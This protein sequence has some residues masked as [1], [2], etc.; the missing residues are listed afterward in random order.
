M[1]RRGAPE[2]K[3]LPFARNLLCFKRRE[4]AGDQQ[5]MDVGGVVVR[6]LHD[7][8]PHRTCECRLHVYEEDR[9]RVHLELG[10]VASKPHREVRARARPGV[11]SGSMLAPYNSALGQRHYASAE[12]RGQGLYWKVGE[13]NLA[14]VGDVAL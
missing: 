5:P 8:L 14:A 10:P 6:R 13:H 1:R 7:Q 2:A 12:P 4:A 3:L 9:K 11:K